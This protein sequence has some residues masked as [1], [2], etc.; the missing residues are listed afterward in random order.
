[1]GPIILMVVRE[2]WRRSH[3]AQR[4]IAKAAARGDEREILL[5]RLGENLPSWVTFPDVERAEWL[6]QVIE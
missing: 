1:V 3:D 4:E 2:Q 6:N 5:A